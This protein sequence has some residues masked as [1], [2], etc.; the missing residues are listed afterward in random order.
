MTTII[1]D[2]DTWRVLRRGMN[3]P[4]VSQWQRVLVDAGLLAVKDVD[5]DF[6]PQTEKLTIQFQIAHS[7]P[8]DGVVG[9][10][11]RKRIGFETSEQTPL[12][13]IFDPRWQFLQAVTH[14]KMAPGAR[15][16]TIIGMHTMQQAN[17]PDTAEG[18]AS[19]FAGKRGDAPEASSHVCGDRDSIVQCV[20]PKDQAAGAK[21]GNWCGYHIEQA[22]YAEW[23]AKQ[24]DAPEV[25]AML[26]LIGSHVKMA[27]EFF[28]L[29]RVALTVPET[30]ACIRDALIRQGKIK[31]TL[32]GVVGGICTHK[33]ITDA[34]VGWSKYGLY[35][36]RL[37]RKPWWPD[38]WDC[39]PN[40]PMDRLLELAS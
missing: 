25:H 22:G 20:L 38:H 31:G 17:R 11:T 40:Y 24:W 7:I 37:D 9:P 5:G 29:P 33:N 18:I 30:A 4:D 27:L 8:A 3:G 19:W 21:G 16:V 32:S 28:G 6:G 36:P 13:G 1:I 23:T 12:P 2:S 14:V 10:M 15:K 34:W 35:N 26:K 39:G